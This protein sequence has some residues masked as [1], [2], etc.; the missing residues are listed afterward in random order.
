MLPEQEQRARRALSRVLTR[1]LLDTLFSNSAGEG[2]TFVLLI[3]GQAGGNS[4]SPQL[5]KASFISRA[6]RIRQ[7]RARREKKGAAV[8]A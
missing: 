1:L 3:I 8:T 7:V 5:E 4:C 2:W 6:L